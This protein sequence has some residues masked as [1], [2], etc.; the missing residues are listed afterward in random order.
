[1]TFFQVWFIVTLIIIIVVCVIMIVK[2]SRTKLVVEEKELKDIVNE[3]KKSANP[4]IPDD[5]DAQNAM[6][7]KLGGRRIK[8]GRPKSHKHH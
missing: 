1:M 8:R 6:L 5:I 2:L 7:D 4:K 3:I